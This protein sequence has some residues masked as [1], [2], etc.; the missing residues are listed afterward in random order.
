[1][2]NVSWLLT[3]S[4]KEGQLENVKSLMKELSD[5]SNKN[6]PG[7]LA[8]ECFLSADNKTGH[9]YERYQDSASALTHLKGFGENFAEKFIGC[10]DISSFT[11]YGN[12]DD[13]VKAA[14]K[15]FAPVYMV[16]TNGFER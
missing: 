14:I 12:P 5:F 13:E 9:F 10:L 6:E 3:V 1:M 16:R 2:N 15:P 11:V 8:Y 4:V 7:T